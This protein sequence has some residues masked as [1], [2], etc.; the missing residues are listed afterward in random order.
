MLRPEWRR[1][2]I[3]RALGSWS[4]L[5]TALRRHRQLPIYSLASSLID[6]LAANLTIPL[7]IGLYGSDVG[8]LY[9][10]VLKVLAVPLALIASSVADAF[11]SRL[12]ICA[13]ETPDLLLPLFLRTA[14]GL[15]LLALFPS[16]ILAIGGQ[17][18]FSV[19][20]GRQW[21]VA[22]L[23][24]AISTPWFLSQFVVSPLSRLVFVLRGQESKLIYD[25]VLLVS[26]FAA[27]E[28]AR[29]Q[30]LSIVQTVWAFTIVNTGAYILY[31]FVL[32]HIVRKSAHAPAIA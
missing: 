9:S 21:A 12:A 6:T 17:T 32:L 26:I 5:K 23:L 31:F 11:H 14:A 16:A 25:I 19:V 28:I 13:R 2:R 15:F 30:H 7:L 18:L 20:F 10:L 29:L 24:A 3:L 22:G 1:L 4:T 27:Y 8:G